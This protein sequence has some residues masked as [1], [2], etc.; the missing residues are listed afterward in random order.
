MFEI[1][2][3]LLHSHEKRPNW[4][5]VRLERE[6]AAVVS[7]SVHYDQSTSIFHLSMNSCFQKHP[8][9]ANMFRTDLIEWRTFL[10]QTKEY[11]ELFFDQKLQKTKHIIQF[12]TNKTKPNPSNITFVNSHP[13]LHYNRKSHKP[14]DWNQRD[15]EPT[16]HEILF[17]PGVRS[18]REY[19]ITEERYGE[20]NL[21]IDQLHK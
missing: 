12:V 14:K 4:Y 11:M 6:N 17:R 16:F 15:P 10:K 3:L 2:L 8:K 13:T 9:D 1:C 7:F 20:H 21:D 19:P 5:S 18:I